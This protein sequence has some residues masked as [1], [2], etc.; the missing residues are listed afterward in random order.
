M[1]I[2][3]IKGKWFHMIRTGEKEEE[4]REMKEYWDKRLLKAFGLV[5]EA[6][7]SRFRKPL[8]IAHGKICRSEQETEERWV[9]FRNGYAS[10]SP[11]LYA[12]CTLTIGTGREEWGAEPG[13]VYYVL[14]IKQV[15]GAD[16]KGKLMELGRGYRKHF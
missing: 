3:P 14:K 4:Y 5:T 10:N 12:K 7:R 6:Q 2:L 11:T 9:C 8:C 13:V 15:A 16:Y 1:L